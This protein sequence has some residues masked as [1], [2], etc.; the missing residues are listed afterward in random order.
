MCHGSSASDYFAVY[1]YRSAKPRVPWIM[2]LALFSIMGFVLTGCTIAAA[3]IWRW[4]KTARNPDRSSRQTL[5]GSS[6]FRKLVG[7]IIV[8]SGAPPEQTT[9]IKTTCRRVLMSKLVVCSISVLALSARACGPVFMPVRRSGS[10]K[11]RSRIRFPSHL[12]V[13]SGADSI[14]E[15]DNIP[16]QMKN[17]LK[18]QF[19]KLDPIHLLKEIR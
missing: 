5:D 16:D 13:N 17:L 12:V 1:P 15:N 2:D 19:S 9:S 11:Y 8:M 6:R 18:D 10:S 14:G 3:H 7:C 4:R